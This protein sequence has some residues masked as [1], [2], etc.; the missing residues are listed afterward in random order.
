[1]AGADGLEERVERLSGRRRPM[2]LIRHG[3][4]LTPPRVAL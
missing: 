1:L 3:F 4:R 2:Y